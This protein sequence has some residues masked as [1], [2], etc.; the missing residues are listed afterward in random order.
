MSEGAPGI[1]TSSTRDEPAS[2]SGRTSGVEI[3]TTA[4]Q[5]VGEVAQIGLKAGGRLVKRAVD[6]LPK[7]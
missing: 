4:A 2:A 5:V 1:G 7:P 6:R 3:V